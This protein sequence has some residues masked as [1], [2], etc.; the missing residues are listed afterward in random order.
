MTYTVKSI[1]QLEQIYGEPHERALWKEIDC[2]NSDYQAF[3]RASPFAV[4]SSV[5]EDGTDCSPKGDAAG[6]VQVLDEHT[7]ALPDRPGNNRIDSL[8]NIVLDPRVSLLFLVPGVGET[9]RV[10]GRAEISIDPAVLGQFEVRG[11]LPR[12]VVIVHVETAYF[13]CSKALVRSSLW[14]PAMHVDRASLPSAGDMHRRLS[15]GNFDGA[16][17][18]RDMPERTRA[19]LY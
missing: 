11:K 2:L 8:R 9:L 4:L 14:D 5:G 3:V 16:Q 13:H 10:N 12:T 15:G 18:D 1:E 6:F 7:L 19:G 17:Y